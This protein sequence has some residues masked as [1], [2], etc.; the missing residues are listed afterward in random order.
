MSKPKAGIVVGVIGF[1]FLLLL[2]VGLLYLRWVTVT[3]FFVVIGVLFGVVGIILLSVFLIRKLK[4]PVVAD[5]N[6]LEQKISY[7]DLKLKIKDFVL[8]ELA[9]HFV[10]KGFRLMNV[11]T[12]N[13][14]T[15]IA[16]ATGRGDLR[17]RDI[18][19]L[20]NMQKPDEVFTL[21]QDDDVS[22]EKLRNAA[23]MMSSSPPSRE[24]RIVKRRDALTG[25]ETIEETQSAVVDE[26]AEEKKAA[27]DI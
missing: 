9:E 21:L 11:G 8:A 22:E 1:G 6:S 4:K 16:V 10:L 15:S 26:Q 25:N 5:A 3:S 12:G 27:E 2:L 7:G 13:K 17:G 23:E 14:R 18:A 20:V 24:V 19:V